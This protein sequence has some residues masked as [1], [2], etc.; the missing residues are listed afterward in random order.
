MP[1]KKIIGIIEIIKD[2]KN[3]KSS[4]TLFLIISYPI[5][6]KVGYKKSK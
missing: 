3:K 1:L 6:S 4:L 5:Y 2:K